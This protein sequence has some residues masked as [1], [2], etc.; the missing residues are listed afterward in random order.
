MGYIYFLLSAQKKVTKEKGAPGGSAGFAVSR[1]PAKGENSDEENTLCVC[2]ETAH[3]AKFPAEII[4]LL[5]ITPE[6]PPAMKNIDAKQSHALNLP[7]RYDALKDYL[8]KTHEDAAIGVGRIMAQRN[9][10]SN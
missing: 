6:L 4:E 7:A 2:L 3:P 9:N 1:S 10:G 5:N 8:L